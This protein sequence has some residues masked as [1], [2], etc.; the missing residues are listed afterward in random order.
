MLFEYY[1]LNYDHNKKEIEMFNIFQN[2]VVQKYTEYAVEKY[3]SDPKGFKFEFF[4]SG[5]EP[6]Y[7]FEGFVFE[8]DR[9]IMSQEH[10]RSEYE[11]A[12]GPVF[13][14]KTD[15]FKKID[16]YL[17]AHM[18]IEMIAYEVIR[19]Y[20]KQMERIKQIFNG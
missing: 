17:Q 19:Q 9:I 6:I 5:N 12:A 18:N 4:T 11:I 15:N 16:C 13:E 7:G 2:A 14:E 20:K 8:L 10:Y 1:V 3:L